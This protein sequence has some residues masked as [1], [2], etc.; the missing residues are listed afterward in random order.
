MVVRVVL[1]LVLGGVETVRGV[2]EGPQLTFDPF[3]KDLE[4]GDAAVVAATVAG[5]GYAGKTSRSRTRKKEW[6]R[7]RWSHWREGLS[8]TGPRSSE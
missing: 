3:G 2:T 8:R 1:A 4:Q 6:R 7:R 5:C